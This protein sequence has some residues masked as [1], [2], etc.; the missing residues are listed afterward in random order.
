M[1]KVFTNAEVPVAYSMLGLAQKTSNQEPQ[2]FHQYIFCWTAFNNVYATL[3]EY[4]GL[5]PRL[6][7]EKDGAVTTHRECGVDMPDVSAPTERDQIDVACDA[8]SD[9]LK[10]RLVNHENTRFFVYRTPSWRGNQINK[11]SRGQKLN[12]VLNVGRTVSSE[13]PV[14]SPIDLETYESYAFSQ[15][16]RQ[17]DELS[18]QVVNVLYT[19]RN[20]VVHGGKRAD[21]GNDREVLEKAIPLLTMIVESFL[22]AD[23]L[24]GRQATRRAG[25]RP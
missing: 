1:G 16:H 15:G 8:M 18:R 5:S 12:G 10:D 3:A 14:W 2:P 21:D 4:A 6:R 22:A 7:K 13:D 11:D 23:E 19:V 9:D 20:N 17:R 25:N 24:P